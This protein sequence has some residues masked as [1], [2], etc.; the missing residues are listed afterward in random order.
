MVGPW[1]DKC[2]N[3]SVQDVYS[4]EG[5]VCVCVGGTGHILELSILPA[6]FCCEPKLALKKF[7]NKLDLKSEA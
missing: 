2:T 6:Q 4:G 7:V 1:V 3:Y 5:G